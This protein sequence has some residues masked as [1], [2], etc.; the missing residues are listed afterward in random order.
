M[1]IIR[2]IFHLKFGHYKAAKA[3]LDEAMQKRMMPPDAKNTRVLS[4][5]TGDSYRL[6]FEEGYDSLAAYETSLTEGMRQGDW[7]EWYGRFKPHV[8]KSHREILKLVMQ[9]VAD[10]T[11][12]A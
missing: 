10:R 11:E 1:Y 7:Q 3:L 8:E 4:D 12:T 6:I 2:D 9:E 5:F